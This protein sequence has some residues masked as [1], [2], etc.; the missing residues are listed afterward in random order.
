MFQIFIPAGKHTEHPL[1][2][3]SYPLLTFLCCFLIKRKVL[4]V[5]QHVRRKRKEKGSLRGKK[6]V[7][8]LQIFNEEVFKIFSYTHKVNASVGEL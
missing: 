1:F 4:D 2:L 8:Y 6:K 5:I 3:V 7:T